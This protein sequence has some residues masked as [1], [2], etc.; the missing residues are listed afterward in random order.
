MAS[1]PGWLLKPDASCLK[2]G[3]PRVGRFYLP[4]L[5]PGQVSNSLVR[6]SPGRLMRTFEFPATHRLLNSAEFDAVFKHNHFRVND[7]TLLFLAKRNEQGFN[8]LGMVISKKSLPRAVDRNALKRLIR[9]TFR[10]VDAASLDVIVLSRPKARQVD[11]ATIRQRLV[12]SFNKL[13]KDAEG[14]GQ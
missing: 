8:R 9:E 4:R 13:S 12:A 7:A 11:K 1:V 2:E 6:P 3:A 10:Q 5:T 14:T